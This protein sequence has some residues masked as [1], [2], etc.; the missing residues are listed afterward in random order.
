MAYQS[1]SS[2]SF[3]SRTSDVGRLVVGILLTLLVGYAGLVFAPTLG[4]ASFWPYASIWAAIG[5]G[6]SRVSMK[7][8]LAL[9]FLGTALDLA[10]D[11][12]LGCW[13][14]INLIAY[15]I[16]SIFR[17]R[18]Q[19][20]PSGFVRFMGDL[21]ALLAAFLF[22]RW[23]IGSYLGGMETQ[24][25]LGGFL[26]TAILYLPMRPLYLLTRTERVDG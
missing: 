8:V 19:T 25:I 13:A 17:R 23:I 21:S 4:L 5:W 2:G 11:A 1:A 24:S 10:V 7:P 22:A 12:P 3:W 9:I 18:A 14:A 26:T 16:A 20:D 15:L 6:A